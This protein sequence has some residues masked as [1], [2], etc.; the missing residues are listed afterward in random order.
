ML[1]RS[2]KSRTGFR[3][4]ML[5]IA[6]VFSLAQAALAV[7]ATTNAAPLIISGRQ[8]ARPAGTYSAGITEIIKMLDANIDAQV[9]LAYIQNS[10]IAYNPEATELIALKDHGAS[11]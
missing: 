2:K 1:Y 9:I 10:P 11:T 5:F 8:S 6:V 3:R 7:T 4:G